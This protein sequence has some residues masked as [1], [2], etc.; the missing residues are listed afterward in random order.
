[1]EEIN[2]RFP[3]ICTNGQSK[4]LHKFMK[5]IFRGISREI[6]KIV[7]GKVSKQIF[8][9]IFKGYCGRFSKE[10]QKENLKEPMIFIK[11]G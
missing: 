8:S 11:N 3:L 4:H 6:S 5:E 1:M 2:G 7:P 10:I 9:I